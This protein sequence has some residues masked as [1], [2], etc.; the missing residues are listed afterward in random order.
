MSKKNATALF[1]GSFNPLTLAHLSVIK[2]LSERFEKV[3]VVPT[4]ISPF[5]IGVDKICDDDRLS[6]LKECVFSLENVEVSDFELKRDGVSYTYITVSELKKNNVNLFLVMGTDNIEGLRGWKNI[7]EI[8]DKSA[9]YFVPRPGFPVTESDKEKLSS[10]NCRYEIADFIGADGSSTLVPVANAFGK[11]TSVVPEIVAR[12]IEDRHLY[13]QYFFVR[14]LYEKYNVK[15]SRVEHTYGV[16]KAVIILAGIY[17]ADVKKAILASLLHDCGKYVTVADLE[18][19][20]FCFGDEAKRALPPVEHCYTSEAIA[21]YDLK[22]T[23]E[24]VLGAIRLHTTGDKNMTTLEKIVFCADYVEEGR[25]TPGVE[26]IRE[27]ILFDLDGAMS[28][29]L[30]ATI[31]YLKSK[32]AEIDA[33]TLA[34][35]DWLEKTIRKGEIKC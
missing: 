5:K 29:I 22:I 25:T 15:K 30:D 20:G 28:D 23:D 6:L 18:Q 24:E 27:K 35:R 17:G 12:Y 11:L 26:P 32:N 3:I 7:D 9:V 31:N 8:L 13:E 4:K 10:L 19:N 1:G 34:C 21:R 2:G 16:V 33:R 14:K